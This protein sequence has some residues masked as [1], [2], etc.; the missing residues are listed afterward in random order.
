MI[1]AAESS[2]Q[3]RKNPRRQFTCVGLFDTL[4]KLRRGI[5]KWGIARRSRNL[6]SRCAFRLGVS[7]T[8]AARPRSA[9][10]ARLSALPHHTIASRR[11]FL[12]THARRVL[13]IY[14]RPFM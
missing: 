4:S 2:S 5:P 7:P 6:S 14:D 9:T 10:P 11:T 12:G 13:L 3:M 8:R 1:H